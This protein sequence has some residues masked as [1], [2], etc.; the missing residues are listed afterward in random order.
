METTEK[1][2]K[3]PSAVSATTVKAAK[4]AEFAVIETGGKQYE[5]SVGDEIKIEKLSGEHKEGDTIVFDKV[6]L[7]DNGSDTTIG[8]PHIAG[9]KVSATLT[10]I[11]RAKKIDIIHYKQKSRYF[12]KNGHRQP[13][14]QVKIE[15]FS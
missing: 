9:A 2:K 10:K 5:V 4:T 8:T 12:K 14:Y 11:G 15:S 3:T 1:T 13:F 7:V 6:M